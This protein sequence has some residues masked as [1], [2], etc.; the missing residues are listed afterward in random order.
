MLYIIVVPILLFALFILW[1]WSSVRRGER[2]ID[3]KILRQIEPIA[4]RAECGE[5]VSID[6]VRTVARRPEVRYMFFEILRKFGKPELIPSDYDSQAHQAESALTYWLMH[7]NELQDAPAEMEL[8]ET[9]ARTVQGKPASFYVFRYRMPEG[10][11]AA[12]DGWI[13]G[14]AGPFF[15]D[16]QPYCTNPGAFSR[17]S[18][19]QG[20]IKPADIV[21]WY[22]DVLR[23]KGMAI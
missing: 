15:A 8:L 3:Q 11:W 19:K 21:D 18:D 2:Q 9:V 12:K 6:E 1:R 13:L 4:R 5:A 7:P 23:K 16:D 10:H 22:L 20:T 14:F 17:V